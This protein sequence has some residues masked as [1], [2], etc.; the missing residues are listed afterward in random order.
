MVCKI[1]REIHVVMGVPHSVRT[2]DD[3]LEEVI[4]AERFEGWFGFV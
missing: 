2:G 1:A 4:F 3:F